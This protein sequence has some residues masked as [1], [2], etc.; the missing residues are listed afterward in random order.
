MIGEEDNINAKLSTLDEKINNI[1]EKLDDIKNIQK[2]DGVCIAR[3]NEK[4]PV[5]ELRINN[6]ENAM[7]SD[8]ISYIEQEFKRLDGSF[9]VFKYIWYTITIMLSG[10]LTYVGFRKYK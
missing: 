7:Y 1:L 2:D 5:H 6:I 3:I 8:R 10:I 9:V 4:L